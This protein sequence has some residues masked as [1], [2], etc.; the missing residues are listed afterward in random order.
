MRRGLYFNIQVIL[1]IHS[2]VQCNVT[3]EVNNRLTMTAVNWKPAMPVLILIREASKE[4]A[5]PVLIGF[6]MVRLH[7]CMNVGLQA[8]L[9][10]VYMFNKIL[11]G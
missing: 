6:D 10:R 11:S 3:C 2:P 9:F 4:I 1:T 8:M 5:S 7:H